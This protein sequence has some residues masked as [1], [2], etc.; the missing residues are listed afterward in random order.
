M[1]C[2]ARWLRPHRAQ[3]PRVPG[4][5]VA[6]S[7][8]IE[9]QT[10]AQGVPVGDVAGF[11]ECDRRKHP[12]QVHGSGDTSTIGHIES[13]FCPQAPSRLGETENRCRPS[14]YLEVECYQRAGRAGRGKDRSLETV[15]LGDRLP[16]ANKVVGSMAWYRKDSDGRMAD[17]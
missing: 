3:H 13:I 15:R 9:I 1:V 4:P 5:Q 7:P 6:G 16:K 8:T 17:L 12:G 2:T 10:M 14:I 11:A